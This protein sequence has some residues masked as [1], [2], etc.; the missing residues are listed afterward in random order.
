MRRYL[1]FRIAAVV[2]ATSVSGAATAMA[3]S[4]VP[5]MPAP[6]GGGGGTAVS[7]GAGGQVWFAAPLGNELRLSVGNV[8]GGFST[9]RVS[10]APSGWGTSSVRLV[11]RGVTA[12]LAWVATSG[13]RTGMR[14]EATTCSLTRCA[15]PQVLQR[16][17]VQYDD[18]EVALA[19]NGRTEIAMWDNYD[20]KRG[21]SKPSLSWAMSN[22]T[23]FAAARPVGAGGQDPEL[24]AATN[25]HIFAAWASNAG[26]PLS[27]REWAGGSRL[28]R[29]A[30]PGNS[31]YGEM[32]Q[33]AIAGNDLIV[34]W[35]T[36]VD[37]PDLS[38]GFLPAGALSVAARPLTSG[39]FRSTQLIATSSRDISLAGAPD[40]GAVLAFGRVT[41]N[42]DGTQ[43]ELAT[44]ANRSSGGRFG[45]PVA[46]E[47]DPPAIDVG[48]VAA[49]NVD[50]TATVEWYS[51][52]YGVH[53][54]EAVTIPPGGAPTA[55]MALGLGGSPLA[56]A[57]LGTST[58]VTW[59]GPTD[60]QAETETAP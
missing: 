23:R 31:T 12:H 3:A 26:G 39:R 33:L 40:G 43:S 14:I 30:T 48:P 36:N 44:V 37:L 41:T 28:Q 54:V 1:K 27:I 18:E 9:R 17:S 2:A 60:Y 6:S 25:G 10:R 35:A 24:L 22:G 4:P 5:V 52:R 32:P 47:S 11:V 15:A 21:L 13:G 19:F 20:G 46:L 29:S 34:A 16:L 42:L 38:A 55:P 8:S 51:G 58:V 45:A 59:A 56:V 57:A 7:L 53:D 50:G 49:I